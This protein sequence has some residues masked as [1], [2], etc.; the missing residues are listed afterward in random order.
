MVK[1]EYQDLPPII[2]AE[3]AVNSLTG[4]SLF[5]TSQLITSKNVER[6][7]SEPQLVNATIEKLRAEGFEVLSQGPISITI[8]A[9]QKFMNEFFTVRLLPKKFP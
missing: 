3:A 2:Y 7:Y 6:F 8:A 5:R 4:D 9:P 1:Q